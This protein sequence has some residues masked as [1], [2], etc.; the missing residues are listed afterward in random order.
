LTIPLDNGPPVVSGYRITGQ[1]R[2]HPIYDGECAYVSTRPPLLVPLTKDRYFKLVVLGMRADSIRHAAQFRESGVASA[3][4]AYTQWKRDKAKRDADFRATYEQLKKVSPAAAET[5]RVVMQRQEADIAADSMTLRGQNA[6]IV[7]IQREATD[8]TGAMIRRTQAELD[9][10]S[11]AERRQP[12]A[13]SQHGVEWDWHSDQLA[14]STDSSATPL[15]QLSFT[16]FDRTAAP[17]LPQSVWV[18]IPGLQGLVDH[19]YENLAGD[20]REEERRAAERRTRDATS[21]R[22]HLDWAALE[23]LVARP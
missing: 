2:G 15:M 9:G 16:A 7:Q 18:C 17:D 6:A 20:E 19:S 8:S 12:V 22:D 11:A 21:I 1:F 10:L 23:A 5:L 13:I 4:D 14:G 3:P